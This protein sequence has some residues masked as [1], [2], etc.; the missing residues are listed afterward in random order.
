M[1]R[2]LLFGLLFM[3]QH[4][5]AAQPA[6]QP[7]AARIVILQ[8]QAEQQVS[9]TLD[10]RIK[11]EV[12]DGAAEPKV[13]YAGLGGA[14]WTELKKTDAEWAAQIDS[15]LV[16]NGTQK[17]IVITE[18]RRVST[19]VAVTTEN[20]F[21]TFFADLHS[22]TGYS[23]GTLTPAVAH[24]YARNTAKLDVFCLTDHLESVDDNEWL[25][26]REVAWDANE[27]GQFV[28]FPGLEWTKKWGHINIYDPKTRIWPTE[29]GE[30]YKAAADAGV[31]TKFNHPGDGT[32]SHSGLEYSAIGD[33]TV[34][35]MEVRGLPEEKAFLRALN[36]GWHIAPEGSSDT[37][38]ANWGNVRSW[39]GILAP[40]LSKRN[41]LDAL[42]NRRVYSTLDRNC[43]LTFRVNGMPMGEIVKEPAKDVKI[44]VAVEDTD[45]DPTTKIELFEN[46]IVVQ[47]HEPSAAKPKWETVCSP[48][49]GSY[50]YFVK[51]TQA[52]GNL[53]WSAP[54]WLTVTE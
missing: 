23:D 48:K 50:Y 36:F 40:G 5:M 51:V 30:F 22:H 19:S 52:D 43:V 13:V 31:V 10:V 17:L 21:K 34:Q 45:D 24:D 16:P 37:H 46:G 33:K 12:P 26:T 3:V 39:T 47:T 14:P 53:L 44:E 20:P 32:V 49:P 27:D 6:K 1:P 18:N 42:A 41:I 29:P 2:I 8:P 54:V 9:G 38:S 35:L 28:A 7:P 4:A 15:T 25:D 11:I